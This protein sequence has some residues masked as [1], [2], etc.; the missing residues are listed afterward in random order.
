MAYIQKPGRAPLKN[1]NFETLTNKTP[2][3]KVSGPGDPKDGSDSVN[4]KTYDVTSGKTSGRTVK[5]NS[6]ADKVSKKLGRE[7]NF[8]SSVS[9]DKPKGKA[10]QSNATNRKTGATKSTYGSLS[11]NFKGRAKDKNNLTVD[12]STNNNDSRRKETFRLL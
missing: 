3:K 11:S 5:K 2:L 7:I 10:K 9:Q 6:P 1:K 8:G 12:F 4:V